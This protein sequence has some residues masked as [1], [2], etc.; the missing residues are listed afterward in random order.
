[1]SRQRNVDPSRQA[2]NDPRLAETIV[3]EQRATDEPRAAPESQ[4]DTEAFERNLD[5]I[6]PAVIQHAELPILVD[7]LVDLERALAGSGL[8]A[9]RV[10]ESR[11]LLAEG[12]RRLL[13]KP[14]DEP[15]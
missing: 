7:A 2:L 4:M 1:M 8:D 11:M 5:S 3:P 15:D 9:G 6:L 12:T 13:P 14:S 10:A